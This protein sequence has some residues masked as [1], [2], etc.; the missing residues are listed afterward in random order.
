MKGGGNVEIGEQYLLILLEMSLLFLC[1]L[2]LVVRS[3]DCSVFQ[4]KKEKVKKDN[5]KIWSI[6]DR[7][8]DKRVIGSSEHIFF[9][10]GHY[11]L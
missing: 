7:E 4:L 6:I 8:K 2:L 10:Y 9:F 5:H 3:V 1:S 11:H